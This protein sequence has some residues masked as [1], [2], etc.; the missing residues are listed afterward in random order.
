M[1]SKLGARLMMRGKGDKDTYYERKEARVRVQKEL[2][3]KGEVAPIKNKK[4]QL[5]KVKKSTHQR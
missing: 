2:R 4:E 1:R 5:S 3:I